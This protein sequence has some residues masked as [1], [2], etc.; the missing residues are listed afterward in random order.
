MFMLRDTGSTTG[1]FIKI[2]GSAEITNVKIF[3][4][5]EYDY[6]NGK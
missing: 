4:M 3:I 6:L 1:T 2:V 5:I